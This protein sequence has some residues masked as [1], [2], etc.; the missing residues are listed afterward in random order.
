MPIDGCRYLQ[1]DLRRNFEECHQPGADSGPQEAHRI[2]RLRGHR[3][4]GAYLAS[5]L[6]KKVAEQFFLARK[7]DQAL[8]R[9]LIRAVRITL[10]SLGV[11]TSLGTLGI[12]VSAIVAGLGLTGLALGIA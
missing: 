1:P 11:V 5:L 4:G 9:F 2:G 8:A 12:D 10:V 7:V 3:S 6:F